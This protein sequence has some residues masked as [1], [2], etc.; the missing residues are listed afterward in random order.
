VEGDL[1]FPHVYETNQDPTSADNTNPPGRWDWGPWFWPVFPTVYNLPTGYTD[2]AT[3]TPEA[4]MDTPL[5]NGKAYPTL[6]V[7]PKAYR[8]RVLNASN[9][10][11]VNL[12]LYLAA[13]KITTDPDHPTN[14]NKAPTLCDGSTRTRLPPATVPI[15]TECTEVKMVSFDES[16]VPPTTGAY[17]S[18]KTYTPDGTSAFPTTGGLNGT[19][20]GTAISELFPSGVPDPATAGPHIY[21]IGTEAGLLAGVVDIPST[22]INFEYNKR[23]VTVLNVFE[24][25]LWLG[26]A[27]RADVV[28]DF[29]QYAGKTLILYN[30]SPAPVPAGD[31]RIDYYTGDGDN[32]SV[33]GAPNTLP[34]QGPNTRTIM[35]IV[36]NPVTPTPFSLLAL[37]AAL[38]LA[39]ASAQ[40]MPNI[41]EPGYKTAFPGIVAPRNNMASI[42]TGAVKGGLYQSMTFVTPV[43]IWYKAAAP[44][45]T[46]AP[47]TLTHAAAGDTVSVYLPNKTIQELFDPLYGRMNAT[48]GVE[49]PFTTSLTATT[50][51]LGY[52]DPAT[53]SIEQNETVFWKITHN[54]VDTHPVHFHL[55]NVQ[56]INRVGWDGTVK[57]PLADEIGWKETIK[58]HPLEDVVVA[59]RAKTPTLKG[60]TTSVNGSSTNG[61][62]LPVSNRLM[63]PTQ[64]AGSMLG[65]TQINPVDGTPLTVVNAMANYGWEYVWHCHILGHEENDFMRAV[66]YNANE[67]PPAAPTNLVFVPG[68][69]KLTWTDAATTEYGYKVERTVLT[70]GQPGPFTDLT[71]TVPYTSQAQGVAPLANATSFIDTTRG[72]QTYRYRVTALG[73]Y[74]NNS[75]SLDVDLPPQTPSGL[76]GVASNATTVTLR[77]NAVSNA[78]TGYNVTRNSTVIGSATGTSGSISYVDSTA[79]SATT[80]TYGVIAINGTGSSNPATVS[81]T[82]PAA[83]TVPTAPSGLTGTIAVLN[84]LNDTVV[85][86][87][88][89][90][91]N[92]ET[93]FQIQRS[94]NPSFTNPTNFTVASNVK[95]FTQTVSRTGKLTYYYRVLALNTFGNS[96]WS[97]TKNLTAP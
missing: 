56:V 61:F 81:V 15:A 72:G 78:S 59:A 42:W 57:P 1:W 70:D 40:P 63:D 84:T 12:G 52:I 9:D 35:Q 66:V 37:Q 91:S 55:V 17:H 33:G 3:T 92:N 20:W 22:I 51:P 80:Y 97:N 19:G 2:D 83:G 74:G 5:V 77:W 50:I 45:T 21:Q 96:A 14:P 32:T 4:Y 54:G 38:P 47:T 24:R 8:F 69:N 65:F 75:T 85:L 94:T 46:V 93:G 29:S 67:T 25:G 95:T 34:G 31:P 13:D 87:W 23:S 26:A 68:A 36:V 16:Y 89:D 18:G 30:D 10:R 7:D 58:M 62:G 11:F 76:T 60:V 82:L 48:L 6:T 28:V 49:L 44:S 86:N 43:D 73:G 27:E 90:N 39:Y 41:P 71:A 53:E 79:A 88:N 64:Q